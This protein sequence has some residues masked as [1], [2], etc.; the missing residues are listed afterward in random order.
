[1]ALNCWLMNRVIVAGFGEILIEVAFAGVTERDALEETEPSAAIIVA[2]P[3]KAATVRPLVGVVL[4]MA[5]TAGSEELHETDAVRFRTLP[6]LKVPAAANCCLVANAIVAVAGVTEIETSLGAM[7]KFNE[8]VTESRLAVIE[9]R[10]L[11]W[12]V[13][14]P[15]ELMEARAADDGC[16][17]TEAVKS[18]VELSLNFP[19]A[20]SCSVWP[21]I[22]FVLEAET[23]RDVSFGALGGGGGELVLKA[24]LPPQAVHRASSAAAKINDHRL[25]KC[26]NGETFMR[27]MEAR[28]EPNYWR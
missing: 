7:V 2:F 27:D 16:Q 8:L 26:F 24:P 4:L 25:T 11:D 12:A 5:A 28:V 20:V 18:F 21:T 6:S 13:R 3:D 22:R 9:T 15:L 23:C 10:P 14:I 1:M 17:L 19:V